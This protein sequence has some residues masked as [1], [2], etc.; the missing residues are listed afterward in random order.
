MENWFEFNIE[1]YGA[2]SGLYCFKSRFKRSEKTTFVQFVRGSLQV[3]SPFSLSGYKASEVQWSFRPGCIWRNIHKGNMDFSL[4]ASLWSNNRRNCASY[5][6]SSWLWMWL[7]IFGTISFDII[8]FYLSLFLISS[9][10]LCNVIYHTLRIWCT[11]F[12]STLEASS[13]EIVK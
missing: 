12:I 13:G 7:G 10:Y 9:L 8:H 1:S 6:C 2:W 11:G 3:T 5:D 4:S